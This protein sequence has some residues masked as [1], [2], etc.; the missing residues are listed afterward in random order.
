MWENAFLPFQSCVRLS[1]SPVSFAWDC[2]KRNQKV[3]EVLEGC[4]SRGEDIGQN[5]YP[6]VQVRDQ[7]LPFITTLSA[8]FLS[9]LKCIKKLLHKDVYDDNLAL[10]DS[11]RPLRKFLI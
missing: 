2:H 4:M 5:I 6:N 1:E 10:P 8:L 11:K 3:S 7:R 9:T